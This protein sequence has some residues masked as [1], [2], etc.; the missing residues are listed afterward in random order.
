MHWVQTTKYIF[1]F[2]PKWH[3][4]NSRYYYKQIHLFF[5]NHGEKIFPAFTNSWEN[6][7][8]S[9]TNI[10]SRQ[11]G[12]REWEKELKNYA[13]G[14]TRELK[15]DVRVRLIRPDVVVVSKRKRRHARFGDIRR[16][17][18]IPAQTKLYPASSVLLRAIYDSNRP[19]R[20]STVNANTHYTWVLRDKSNQNPT[21]GTGPHSVFATR[22]IVH[23]HLNSLSISA[24]FPCRRFTSLPF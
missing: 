14:K 7:V 18:G 1:L 24:R 5:L 11:W 10:W 19:S 9:H 21:M 20:R 16:T 2:K 15:F 17:I 8:I 12:E 6:R 22:C 3:D 4:K 23:R 13:N